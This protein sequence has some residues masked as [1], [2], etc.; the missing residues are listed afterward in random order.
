MEEE[1]NE[2]FPVVFKLSASAVVWRYSHDRDSAAVQKRAPVVVCMLK[3]SRN[4]LAAKLSAG[5]W[6]CSAR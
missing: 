4:Y 2:F 3:R 1:V 6:R 5:V